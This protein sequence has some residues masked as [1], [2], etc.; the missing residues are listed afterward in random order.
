MIRA[1]FQSTIAIYR[2]VFCNNDAD[3]ERHSQLGE[4]Q[5]KGTPIMVFQAAGAV[6]LGTGGTRVPGSTDGK[7]C[8]LVFR[9]YPRPRVDGL[10][11]LHQLGEAVPN[12]A[13]HDARTRQRRSC[14][15]HKAN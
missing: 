12:V 13:T 2:V 15:S 4:S 7:S 6:L 9:V 8:M 3:L 11:C 14:S 5:Q 10:G 1:S